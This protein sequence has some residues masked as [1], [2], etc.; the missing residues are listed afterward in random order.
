M[1]TIAMLMTPGARKVALTTHVTTSVGWLGA[2]AAFLALAIAGIANQDA[3]IVRSAYVAM[4]LVTWFV[5]VPMSV[6]S[7]ASG[8]VQSL[9]TTWGLFRHYWIVTKLMLTALATI[10]L[11]VHTQPIDRIAAVALMRDL[12]RSDLWQLR[13]QLIGDA[14]AALFVLFVTT[15]LS[16]YKPWGMTPY[17]LRKQYEDANTPL[18][19]AFGKD[20][21][22][23][24][25]QQGRNVVLAIVAFVALLLLLH[26]ATGGLHEH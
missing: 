20:R 11:L 5:I 4:H 12:S 9:G 21:Q 8:V 24:R 7:F 17:G 10:I 15:I 23:L 26:L 13:L 16:V 19:R 14:S 22:A 1:S 3:E 25:A 2:V 6:A 18:R